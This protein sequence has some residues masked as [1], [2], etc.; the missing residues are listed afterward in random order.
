MQN[1]K[2]GLIGE[3]RSVKNIILS[4]DKKVLV[5]LISIPV[6]QTF[7][8]YVTSRSFFR[9]NLF[10]AFQS[11][12]DVYLFEYL[13]WFL[14][15]FITYFVFPVLIIKLLLGERINNFGVRLGDWKT[16]LKIS[17][18]F[19]A[20]MLPIIWIVSASSSFAAK[21]PHLLSL[22]EVWS[23]FFIYEVAMLIY[24]F[25]WEFIWRG[26]LLFGLEEKFGYYA[27]FLQMIPF[28]ILHNG[29][30]M[31][32]TFG[33]ILGGIAL[34]LLAFR[35]RSFIYGVL[36][37]LGIMFSLD[38]ICSLRFRADDYGLGINSAVNLFK[39]IF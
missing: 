12:P 33:A 20:V 34:G 23:K 39:E 21:Y 7:S 18:L 24:M 29:K 13:F 28:V 1:E 22:R 36:V 19:L 27:V 4:L 25:A 8:W 38:F 17:A 31:P 14:G 26:F 10:Q 15:D 30:P 5:I 9:A 11:N 37:H 2:S 6:L 16:G 35:T 32:E 3:L